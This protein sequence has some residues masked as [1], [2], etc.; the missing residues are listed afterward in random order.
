MTKAIPIILDTDIGTNP[1]DMFALVLLV[2]AN[3]DIRMIITGN[4]HVEQ[5]SR[6]ANYVC[7]LLGKDLPV[8]VGEPTGTIDFYSDTEN[9]PDKP[10]K[11]GYLDA[12]SNILEQ[13]DRVIYLNISSLSNIA[14]IYKNIPPAKQKIE[15]IQMGLTHFADNNWHKFSDTNSAADIAATMYIYNNF[16]PSLTV[17]SHTTINDA[18]RVHPETRLFRFLESSKLPI[19]R[20][21]LGSL[22]AFYKRRGIWPAMHDPLTASCTLNQDFVTFKPHRISIE[23]GNYSFGHGSELAISSSADYLKFMEYFSTTIINFLE[24]AEKQLQG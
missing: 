9:L 12:I 20:L 1:D 7:E 4:N 2:A 15:H 13:E 16:C 5:R 6:L 24:T 14:S 11:Y 17:G 10:L 3:A 19:S 22:Q 8:F 23:K 21:L 18:L